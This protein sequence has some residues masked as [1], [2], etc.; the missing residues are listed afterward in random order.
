[1]KP[2]RQSA[3]SFILGLLLAMLPA[4]AG[5]GAAA[6]PVTAIQGA[7]I[8]TLA[9]PPIENGTLIIRGARIAAVGQNL[10]I[11]GGAQVIKATGLEVYPGLIDSLS[12]LGLTEIGAV[13]ATVD[14][15][16]LGTFNPQLVAATAVH[17]ASEHIP[18]ARANGITHVVSAPT[19][20][21][22]FGFGDFSGPIIP[23]QASLLHLSGWT[24]EEM[25]IRSSVGM[26]LHW[27]TLD[28]TTFDFST[29]SIKERPFTEVKKEFD[30]KVAELEDWVTAAQHY[31][32]ARA[33][34]SPERVERDLK[35]EALGPVVQGNLPLIVMANDDRD[36]KNALEFAEKHKLKIILA[37]GAEA[38]KV[39][40]L[41]KEK[42]IPVILR[43][44]QALP[45]QE[46]EPYD[47]PFTTPGELHAA[48]IKIAFA[49]FDSS[50]SRT[51][52]YEAANAVPYGLPWE[53]A[54]KAITLYPAQI[55]GVAD[56]LGTIEAGKLA[57]L[58]VTDGDPLE[59][60]TQVRYLFINGQLTST[61]NKHR[62]LYEKYRARP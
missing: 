1:M 3:L 20:G 49:T 48:G 62:Q 23:G 50:D 53:E 38:W 14:T 2:T 15:S 19:G 13:P 17:P 21:F 35:L 58:M 30:E 54:L 16:E 59:I 51:L 33:Q 36:I 60:Q 22:F 55:L 61:D 57:N 11:P 56:R 46:D 43:P 44:T 18:V 4:P 12:R 24:I 6:E 40:D 10:P 32:Q 41:L 28:T 37:G 25:L 5:A 27:P 7:K 8:Y 9:G 31:A 26:V 34:G 29:F 42:N 39:K 52:P 45:G 47:K